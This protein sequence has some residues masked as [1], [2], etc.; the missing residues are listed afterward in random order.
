M[1]KREILLKAA[2]YWKAVRLIPAVGPVVMSVIPHYRELH[3]RK[4]EACDS[5]NL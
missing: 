3:R 5:V 1:R 2:P 4:E